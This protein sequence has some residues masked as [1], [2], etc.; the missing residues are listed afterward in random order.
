MARVP[1]LSG[2]RLVVAD[3]PPAAVVL[4]PRP[5]TEG[6]ADVA[7]AVRDALRYPLAGEPLERVLRPGA[8]VT[9]VVEPSALPLPSAPRDPRQRALAATLAELTR[10]GVPDEQVTLLVACGL[11]RRPRAHELGYVVTPDLARRFHGTAV[12]HDAEDPA[13]VEIGE[14]RRINPALLD[15]DAVIV[16]TAAETVLHGGP[17]ALLGACDAATLRAAGAVSLLET[18]SST[19]WK[20]AL[21]VEKALR[22]RCPVIG[23]SL[24]LCNPRITGALHGWPYAPDSGEQIAR[25]PLRHLYGLLPAPVRQRVLRAFPQELA[26]L[27]IYAGPPSVAHAE[28]LLRAIEERSARLDGGP[29]DAICVGIPDTTLH[30]PRERPN[31]VLAASLGL[32]L[33]LRL[34]RDGFPVA[35]G[36]TAILTSGFQRRFQHPTQAPYRAFMQAVVRSG[37][38]PEEL[39]PEERAAASDERALREYRAGRGCHPLLPYFDWAGCQPALSR[40]GAVLVAGCRDAPAAQALGFVPAASVSVALAMAQGRAGGSPRVGFLLAPPYF[41]VALTGS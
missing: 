5:P 12:I 1:L 31:P 16:V 14:G 2:S 29:L 36:G 6:I 34:W 21:A 33:A 9:V 20:A 19:G 41:P 3:A 8:R 26:A 39:A 15:A 11:E 30:L 27:A 10:L 37:R 7:A 4:R 35:D 18:S 24:T 13:L 22:E 28:A 17:A 40:L 25:D 32:G 23:V 38:T